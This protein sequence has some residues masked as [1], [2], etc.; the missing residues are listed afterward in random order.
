MVGRDG[1]LARDGADAI[2]EA[3]GAYAAERAGITARARGRFA[4]REWVEGQQD[5]RERLDLRDRAL[6]AALERVRGVL[7]ACAGDR[8]LWRRVKDRYAGDVAGSGAEEVALTF[9]NSVCRRALGTIGVL[10]E[11]EF[12]A[13]DRPPPEEGPSPPVLA[14]APGAATSQ[15]LASILRA[16][17]LDAAWED[18]DSDARLAATELDAHLREAPDGAPIERVEMAGPVFY[19]GKGAYLVGRIWRRGRAAPLV[20]ALRHGSRGVVLD[21]ALFSREDASIVFSFTRSYFHAEVDRPRALVAFLSTILPTKRISELYTSLGYNEHGKAELFRELTEHLERSGERFV[22]ARGAR[23]LV[24]S[25]FTLPGLDVVLKVIRDE[26]PPPKDVTRDEIMGKYRHVFRHDRAGRLVDAQEFQHLSFPADRFS[27][28]LLSDLRRTCPLHVQEGGGKVHIAHLYAER[29]VI[30]LDLFVR[31]S[32]EWTARQ[33]VLDYG[34]ALRDLAATDTFTGDLLLKNFG[35]TRHGR[36]ISYDYDELQ[37]VTDCAFR[38]LPGSALDGGG[39]E[40]PSF[41]VGPRDVFPEELLPFLGFQGRLRDVF[42]QAHGELLTARWWRGI[43]ERLRAGE[44][45]D[46]FPYREDQRLHHAR[47]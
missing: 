21:A 20:L 6:A 32:D 19:R 44:I 42:L 18:L 28:E 36:V 46:V 4:G 39:G 30:P 16:A 9:F 15:L 14:H 12:L 40:E 29:R 17:P 7:G 35:V 41:Y 3:F 47:G 10:P 26:F 33:A 5:A 31:E 25:V 2:R 27:E 11:V 23:G 1:A 37:R 8:S 45:A 13:R 24:M 43:Q 38:D 22:P 34:R